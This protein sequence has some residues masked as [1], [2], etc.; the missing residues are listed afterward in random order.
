MSIYHNFNIN[1][2]WTGNQGEGTLTYRGYTRDHIIFVDGK[3]DLHASADPA[4]RGNPQRYN[5]EEMLVAAVSSCHMLWY[6]H[7]CTINKVVVIDYTDKATGKMFE[8]NGG[9]GKFEEII[10]YPSIIVSEK[11]MIPKAIELHHDANKMCFISN[12]LN[13]PVKHYPMVNALK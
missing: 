1:L 13:F 3:P 5:P 4:F 6:L 2:E 10:L 7:L 11:P 9:S 8:S 12:S